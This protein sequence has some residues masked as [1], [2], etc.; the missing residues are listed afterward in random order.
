MAQ[1]VIPNE[2]IERFEAGFHGD[3][4]RPNDVRKSGA[5]SSQSERRSRSA[6]ADY[7]EARTVWNGMI[8]KHPAMIARCRSVGDVI[9]AVNFARETDLLVAVRGG[10]HNVAGTAV[11]DD[12]LVID[13]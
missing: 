4:I 3:L 6:D 1:H 11:C 13:L 10:G 5:F 8:D 12:G 2:Q 9:S 7:D